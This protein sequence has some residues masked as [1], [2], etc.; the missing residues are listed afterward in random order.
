MRLRPGDS[1]VRP[2][3]A[4]R[5]A[6]G[7]DR[8]RKAF[9]PSSKTLRRRGRKTKQQTGGRLATD[10]VHAQRGNFDSAYRGLFA[11]AL[12]V[13]ALEIGD[14]VQARVDRTE[15]Q[16]TI[17]GLFRRLDERCDPFTLRRAHPPKMRRVMSA[18][19]EVGER[20]LFEQRR[21][22]VRRPASREK[23]FPQ[24]GRHD[25]KPEAHSWKN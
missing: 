3:R 16:H 10:V 15:A 25:H 5:T 22:D 7:V 12:F 9:H 23:L 13:H 21:M 14:G 4:G 18:A 6:S 2:L 19:D 20:H 24:I 1:R 8:F 11:H 17:A